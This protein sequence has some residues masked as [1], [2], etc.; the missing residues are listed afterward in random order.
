MKKNK[1]YTHFQSHTDNAIGI[2]N[3][4]NNGNILQIH[5]ELSYPSQ[6]KLKIAM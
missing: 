2:E 4:K 1:L 3:R 6:N 5:I